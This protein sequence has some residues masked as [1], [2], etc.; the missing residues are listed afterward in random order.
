MNDINVAADF[1]HVGNQNGIASVSTCSILCTI[2][3]DCN[4]F[5]FEAGTDD[6][7]LYRKSHNGPFSS[8]SDS[9]HIRT[10]KEL[11]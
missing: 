7:D 10:G 5:D 1:D 3:M 4:G 8:G 6:C 11:N 9:L 2:N